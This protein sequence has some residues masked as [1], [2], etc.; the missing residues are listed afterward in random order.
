M[1]PPIIPL[2]IMSFTVY[3]YLNHFLDGTVEDIYM[4]SVLIK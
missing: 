4:T 1:Y 2:D 3:S